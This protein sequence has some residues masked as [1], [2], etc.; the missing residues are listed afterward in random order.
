MFWGRDPTALIFASKTFEKWLRRGSE[1]FFASQW[2]TYKS[3]SLP[4]VKF[5]QENGE[6][7]LIRRL[8]TILPQ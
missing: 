1:I 7:H 3:Y 4:S 6:K 5:N 8:R 2:I